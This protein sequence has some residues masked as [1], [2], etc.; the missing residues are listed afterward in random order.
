MPYWPELGTLYCPY[1]GIHHSSTRCFRRTSRKERSAGGQTGSV[2]PRFRLAAEVGG[3]ST[4]ERYSNTEPDASLPANSDG[5][6]LEMATAQQRGYADELARGQV[7]GREVGSIGSVEFV[8]ERQVGA[9]DL[10][11]DEVIHG[12]PGL[13]ESGL[14]LVEQNLD[15]VGD[16]GGGLARFIQADASC[17]GKRGAGQNAVTER[18]LRI[19]I[20]KVDG[21]AA[22]LRRGLGESAANREEPSCGKQKECKTCSSI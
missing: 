2:T 19:G 3:A 21:A 1:T 13:L 12:H 16:F 11:I 8:V 5:L 9:G 6:D 7:L 10:N 17:E 14:D 4:G 20:G 18:Q 15:F 22:W